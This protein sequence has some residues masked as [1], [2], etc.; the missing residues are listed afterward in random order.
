MLFCI[1]ALGRDSLTKTNGLSVRWNIRCRRSL[2][3]HSALYEEFGHPRLEY[4][5]RPRGRS[6]GGDT[7][8]ARETQRF[9]QAAVGSTMAS[10]LAAVFRACG[11]PHRNPPPF[12][13]RSQ[14]CQNPGGALTISTVIRAVLTPFVR[15]SRLAA[16]ATHTRAVGC[17]QQCV[18]TAPKQGAGRSAARPPL[19]HPNRGTAG[20]I[21]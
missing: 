19:H 21:R 13:R 9:W 3:T 4:Q 2:Q 17:Q 12:S 8:N 15:L 11:R 20:P 14:R 16:A 1:S 18:P 10:T 6:G 7:Q 5:N